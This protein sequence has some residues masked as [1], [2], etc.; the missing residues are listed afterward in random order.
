ML[1]PIASIILTELAGARFYGS[2]W[3]Q[4][5]SLLVVLLTL[6]DSPLAGWVQSRVVPGPWSAY[7][8]L[9][10]LRNDQ[11]IR[12]LVISTSTCCKAPILKVTRGQHGF[13]EILAWMP[14]RQAA[15]GAV[16]PDI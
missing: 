5:H 14:P 12:I 9:L 16:K 6:K 4:S 2:V 15:D 10:L 7:V 13:V 8:A 11:G 3:E 1:G